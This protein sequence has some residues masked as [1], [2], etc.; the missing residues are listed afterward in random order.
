[1]MA[2]RHRG[3]PDKIDLAVQPSPYFV[4]RTYEVRSRAERRV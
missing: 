1:M 2:G 3:F 4:Q